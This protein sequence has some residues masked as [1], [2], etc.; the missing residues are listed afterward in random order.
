MD[1]L[2][3]NI[4]KLYFKYFTAAFGSSLIGTIYGFVDTIVVGQNQGPDGPAAL[5][6]I[7]PVWNIYLWIRLIVCNWRICFLHHHTR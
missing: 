5:A 2:N 6:V 1:L 4:K 3:G 7:A